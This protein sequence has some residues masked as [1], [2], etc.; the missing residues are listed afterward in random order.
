MTLSTDCILCYILRESGVF[1][2]LTSG[3]IE[4]QGEGLS[5]YDPFGNVNE[6]VSG[7]RLRSWSVFRAGFF[8]LEWSHILPE[9]AKRLLA[10][11]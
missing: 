9:D 1:G 8:I 6:Y 2:R 5:V 7:S 3:R 11:Q 4:R 10:R